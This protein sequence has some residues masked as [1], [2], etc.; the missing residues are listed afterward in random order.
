MV[1]DDYVLPNL[2][3]WVK[4]ISMYPDRF[5]IGSD[6]VGTVSKMNQTLKPYD[7]LLAA[8]PE[9]IR[10]KVAH[11]NFANLFESMS[12]MRRKNGFGDKGIRISPDYVYSDKLHVRPD[13]KNSNIMEKR[14][15]SLQN[16]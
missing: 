15:E 14:T 2:E 3:S 4:L 12:L 13:F 7:K 6:V 16:K 11:D 5:M 1:L 8:L 10:N 9:K